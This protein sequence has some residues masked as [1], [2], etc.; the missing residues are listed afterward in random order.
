MGAV[1]SG[2]ADFAKRNVGQKV[3]NG[4]CWTLVERALESAGAKTSNDLTKNKKNF[5]NADYVWGISISIDEL[6]AG[7]IIQFRNHAYRMNKADGSFEEHKRG[8]HSA[9][10]ATTAPIIGGGIVY[11]YESHVRPI[12]STITSEDVQVNTI[13]LRTGSYNGVG[14]VVTGT[15]FCYRPIPK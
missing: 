4:Q 1:S 3:G 14:V 15:V 2:V 12:G 11:V 9:I 10:V 8:H 7:D 13:F 5:A 6:Q